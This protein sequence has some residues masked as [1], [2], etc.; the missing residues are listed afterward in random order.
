MSA[1]LVIAFGASMLVVD[2]SSKVTY[3]Q[4][5]AVIWRDHTLLRLFTIIAHESATSDH[6]EIKIER[7][8]A[9]AIWNLPAALLQFVSLLPRCSAPVPSL[10]WRCSAQ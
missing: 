2:K 10:D 7:A 8:A 6:R 4:A 9:L 1:E 3:T 5:Q